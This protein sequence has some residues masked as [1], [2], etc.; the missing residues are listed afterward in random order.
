M[1]KPILLVGLGGAAGSIM[2]Y[3]VSV[4][5][6]KYA[7]FAFPL[8]T[9]L[10]NLIGCFCIGLFTNIIPSTNLRILLI[11]GFCGGFTTFSTFANETLALINNNQYL[12]AFVYALSS[13]ILGVSAVWLGMW[14]AK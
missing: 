1:I 7:L 4:F 2:R 12:L 9:F 3:L 8:G 10:I 14:I 13:C 11:I 6:A 5:V